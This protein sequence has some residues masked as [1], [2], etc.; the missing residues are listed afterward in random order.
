MKTW[1]LIPVRSFS[2]G[3]SRLSGLGAGRCD[4]AR[5]L[6]AHVHSVVAACPAFSGVLVASNGDDLAGLARDILLDAGPDPLATIVDRGLAAL[7][8]RGADAAVV[9][10]ADLPLLAAGDLLRM[11]AA[12]ETA[13]VVAAPDRDHL[14]TNALGLRLPAAPTCFGNPDSYP[15]HVAAAR[16]AGLR[17]ATIDRDGLAFDL[18]GPADLADLTTEAKARVSRQAPVG[19]EPGLGV[20]DTIEQIRLRARG[21]GPPHPVERRTLGR[22]ATRGPGGPS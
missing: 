13:D 4:L 21:E 15:R 20:L 12:L 2:T 8:A 14:G 1:A 16:A 3:K 9:V 10:M 18:D 17:L 11:V 22:D 5:A 7:V 19:T 6:F